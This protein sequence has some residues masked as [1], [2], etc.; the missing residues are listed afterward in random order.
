VPIEEVVAVAVA[1]N[2]HDYVQSTGPSREAIDL[3][4]FLMRLPWP[5]LVL[6]PI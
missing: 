1:D 4:Q 6:Q 3:P 2:A 5:L